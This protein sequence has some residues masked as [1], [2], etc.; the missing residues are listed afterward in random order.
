VV[1][2][3]SVIT[4]KLLKFTS[5]SQILDA[6]FILEPDLAAHTVISVLRRLRQEDCC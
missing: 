6:G 4:V 5:F 1:L 3:S 2:T